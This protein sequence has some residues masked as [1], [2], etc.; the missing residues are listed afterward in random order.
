[1]SDSLDGVDQVLGTV[2]SAAGFVMNMSEL[3][4]FD[5]QFPNHPL[6]MAQE[7]LRNIADS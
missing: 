3:P 4:D 6:S 1:M 2:H 7:L 5:E